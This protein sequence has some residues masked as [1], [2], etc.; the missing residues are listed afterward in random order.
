M[1]EINRD[2]I[3]RQA[4]G[5][6]TALSLLSEYPPGQN[7]PAARFNEIR[8]VLEQCAGADNACRHCAHAAPCR[9][10]FDELS[11]RVK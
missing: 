8:I 4:D 9:A 7:L 2:V 6:M 11:G 10:A 1:G 3:E 5:L